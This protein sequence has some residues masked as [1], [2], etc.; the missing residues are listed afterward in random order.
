MKNQDE[1]K[2][3]KVKD[4]NWIEKKKKRHCKRIHYIPSKVNDYFKIASL[5]A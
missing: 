3:R 1:V 5:L 4:G 2:K